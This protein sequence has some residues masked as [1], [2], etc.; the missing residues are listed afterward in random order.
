MKKLATHKNQFKPID[1]KVQKTCL[2]KRREMLNHTSDES[3][4]VGRDEEAMKNQRKP[5]T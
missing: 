4:S 5:K 1:Y 2:P 3:N